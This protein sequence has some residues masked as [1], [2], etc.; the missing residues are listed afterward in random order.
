[1]ATEAN[2]TV[3]DDNYASVL[4]DEKLDYG[5]YG[6]YAT[7]S[8]GSSTIKTI[9]KAKIWSIGL[10]KLSAGER[11]TI[12]GENLTTDN[13]NKTTVFLVSEDNTEYCQVSVLLQ[14]RAKSKF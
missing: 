7:N 13:D 5:V 1:K 10:Y 14:T 11:L 3:V 4:I 12:L 6:I 8:S 2:F 9:N